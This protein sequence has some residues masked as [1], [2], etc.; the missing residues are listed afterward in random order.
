MAESARISRGANTPLSELPG[1]QKDFAALVIP[2]G[3][4]AAKNLCNHATVA[5][6]DASKLTV[7]SDVVASLKAFHAAE[8]PIG[9]CC[10]APVIA[11]AT[12][13]CEVTV[14]EH[15]GDK[16][17]FGGTVGAITGYG[18][19][20]INKGIDGVHVDHANKVVTSPAYMYDGLPHEI[21]DNV[22]QMI[23]EVVKLA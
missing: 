23:D 19:T 12:L 22:G 13:K 10:I 18:G 9:L 3:F 16:W 20:H 1:S 14:G 15:E 8:K 2:G 6:G 21:F 11:A 7:N 4:G 17:P 5:Q